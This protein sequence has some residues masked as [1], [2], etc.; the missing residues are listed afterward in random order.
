MADNPRLG[1]RAGNIVKNSSTGLL[2]NVLPSILRFFSRYVFLM[3]FGDALL[4]VNSLFA[5]VV[6]VFS[7]AEIG[8]FAAVSYFLY[9]PIA[10]GDTERIQSLLSLFRTLNRFII[11]GVTVVGICFIPFLQFIKTD[12]PIPGLLT[13]YLIFLAQNITSYLFSYR[14][15]YLSASQKAYQL[16]R[17][18]LAMAFATEALQIIV[19]IT[20][21]NFTAYLLTYV[22]LLAARILWSNRLIVARY[23]ETRFRKAK[24]LDKETIRQFVKKTMS[25]FVLKVSELGVSQTDSIIV[26]T[27]VDVTQ[28]G[29]VSNYMAIRKMTALVLSS[30]AGGLVPSLGI[31]SVV[32][33]R[34]KQE[35]SFRLYNF[36]NGLLCVNLF[37]CLV[38]LVP[39][40]I[41]L[42]FGEKRVLDDLTCFLLFFNVLYTGLLEPVAVLRDAMGQYERDKWINIAAFVCNL[43]TSVLFVLLFGLPGVFMGT[44]CSTT[45][46]YYRIYNVLH[47]AYGGNC[48]DYYAKAAKTLLL[49]LTVYAALHWLARPLIWGSLS[50]LLGLILLGIAT[51]LVTNLFFWAFHR[52]DPYLP[53]TMQLIRRFLPP[54][55]GGRAE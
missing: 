4:G 6:T 7:F 30:L 45:V 54:K 11:L 47:Y 25:L 26:S 2:N 27:M 51:V 31:L 18:N 28:W 49:G 17:V 53:L 15:A 39:P 44:L 13:Y 33:S 52:R 38:I 20:T 48:M 10:E 14:V 5:D 16:A 24:P 23:P 29:Y 42:I 41:Q 8:V 40:F 3:Y 35:D 21:R 32:E 1:G 12:E 36:C 37:A 46:T 50:N 55:M 19:T 22:A 34:E 43:I 9:K